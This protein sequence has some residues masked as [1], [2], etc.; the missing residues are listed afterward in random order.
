MLVEKINGLV[1]IDETE[2][3]GFWFW[4]Q[5]VTALTDLHFILAAV[6]VAACAPL[7]PYRDDIYRMPPEI[8][9]ALVATIISRQTDRKLIFATE[10]SDGYRYLQGS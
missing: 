7:Y 4:L 1:C 9:T 6:A 2:I 10:V 3:D 5:A 8:D